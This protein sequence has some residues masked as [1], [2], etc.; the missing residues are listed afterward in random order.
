M[1]ASKR[2]DEQRQCQEK[3][4]KN[5]RLIQYPRADGQKPLFSVCGDLLLGSRA[6]DSDL[7][8]GPLV[9]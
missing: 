1:G 3:V 6:S 8:R 2:E 4:R 9:L 7:V 5:Q